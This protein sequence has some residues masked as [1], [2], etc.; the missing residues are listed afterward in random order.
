VGNLPQLFIKVRAGAGC[1]PPGQPVPQ[2]AGQPG[3]RKRDGNREKNLARQDQDTLIRGQRLDRIL[4]IQSFTSG[5]N[6]AAPLL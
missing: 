5:F 6:A 1:Q 3:Q 2:L 4:E